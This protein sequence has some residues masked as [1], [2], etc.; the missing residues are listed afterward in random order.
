MMVCS[1]LSLKYRWESSVCMA[2]I[3]FHVTMFSTNGFELLTRE[4]DRQLYEQRNLA[5]AWNWNDLAR[6]LLY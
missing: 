3:K 5:D 1:P 4:C 6:L 2:E